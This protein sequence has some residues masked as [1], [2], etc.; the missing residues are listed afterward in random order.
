M[1]ETNQKID[2]YLRGN[3]WQQI[4]DTVFLLPFIAVFLWFLA[5]NAGP[6]VEVDGVIATTA[7][8]CT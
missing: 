6:T 2:A 1:S 4:R 5:P 8:F 3:R 7:K